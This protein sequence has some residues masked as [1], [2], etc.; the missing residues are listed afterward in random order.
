MPISLVSDL[1]SVFISKQSGKYDVYKSDVDGANKSVLLAATGN[2]T[3]DNT[4]VP[5]PNGEVAA[6]INNRDN[7]RDSNGYLLQTLT[8]IN[9]A[10]GTP[11]IIDHSERI[12]PVDWFGDR[13]VYVIIKAGASAANP[14]RYQLM[15]YDFRTN[16]RLQLDHANSFNDIVSANGS[17]Y[18]ATSNA[19]NGGVSQF[20]RIDA[21]NSNKQ[22][23]LVDEVW[24]IFRI[25]YNNFH[26]VTGDNNYTYKIGDSKP[27][28]TSQSYDGQS[29]LY[30]DSPDGMHSLWVDQRDGKG[31]LLLHD[32]ANNK[33]TVLA[34]ETGLNYPV[35]WL[36]NDLIVYRINSPKETADYIVSTNGGSPKKIADV[37]DAA[38][39][40]LWYYYWW[41]SLACEQ[42]A[43]QKVV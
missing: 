30:I 21:D 42:V 34:Q 26:L 6:L 17:I 12:Q 35:R 14:S 33:D 13:F 15:S 36:G 40:T 2:E 20:N 38:G 27:A 37:T 41:R 28:S 22:V 31:T 32:I 9:I 3:T 11:T 24:N 39:L 8:L 7:Q 5:N 4:L 29:R 43:Y 1:K 25:D 18:Y 10:T 19:Y 23:L 16:Q